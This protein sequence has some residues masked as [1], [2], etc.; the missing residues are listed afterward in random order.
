MHK[1]IHVLSTLFCLSLLMLAGSCK[2][3]PVT[4]AATNPEAGF[5]FTADFLEVTFTNTSTNATSYSWDFGDG[6]TPATSTSE[7]PVTVTYAAAGTYQVSLQATGASGTTPNTFT[8]QVTVEAVPPTVT[9]ASFTVEVDTLTAIFTNTSENATSYSWDFGVEGIDTDVST[10]ESPTYTY[11]ATGTYE[12][13]LIATGAN[14]SDS[15]T[16]QVE[17]TGAAAELTGLDSLKELLAGTTNKKWILQRSGTALG[18]GPNRDDNEWF[19]LSGAD[20]GNRPCVLDDEY[21]FYTDGRFKNDTKGT[22][23]VSGSTGTVPAWSASSVGVETCHDETEAGLFTSAN[24]VDFSAY[25]NGGSYTFEV[26]STDDGTLT[27]KL[28]GAGAYIGLLDRNNTGNL[29]PDGPVPTELNFDVSGMADGESIDSIIL[30]IPIN[31]GGDGY[32]NYYLVS[33]AN[34]ADIPDVPSAEPSAS[35]TSAADMTNDL[36]YTFT[37]T[38]TN[39]TSYSWDFGD[40]TGTSTDENPTYTYAAAGSYDVELT[41]TGA[42]GTTPSI[43]TVT[44]LAGTPPITSGTIFDFESADQAPSFTSF[45]AG[46]D[47]S[48]AST[49]TVSKVVNS[50]KTAPNVSDSA[51]QIAQDAM[52]RPWAGISNDLGN[53]ISFDGSD[54]TFSISVYTGDSPVGAEVRLKFEQVGTSANSIEAWD[55]ISAQNTWEVLTFDFRAA[56]SDKTLKGDHGVI[57]NVYGLMAL[58]FDF[59][60]GHDD[61]KPNAST[62]LFDDIE[63]NSN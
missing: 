22:A 5:T 27:V 47:A 9:N 57:S 58:F 3:D 63:L 59:Q 34:D 42:S 35:F 39:A 46:G 16:M 55:T 31:G 13:I 8:V 36:M 1:F 24:G 50:S 20:L 30:S 21:V 43:F 10:D 61:L 54:S 2:D 49:I 51:Y 45:G 48:N 29:G 37:N 40:G 15:D 38:S 60:P 26:D 7:G 28:L 53:V 25:A 33:Y 23:W 18:V 6:A 14:N 17:V 32:W 4:P 41:A 44:V 56:N 19:A 52:V 11:P 12:V 62:W